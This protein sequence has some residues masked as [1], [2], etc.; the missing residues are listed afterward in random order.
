MPL[1][2]YL[3]HH[4]LL[5]ILLPI[6]REHSFATLSDALMSIST[7]DIVPRDF[8]RSTSRRKI[9]VMPYSNLFISANLRARLFSSFFEE[10]RFGIS[11]ST[12]LNTRPHLACP[13]VGV[14]G[15]NFVSM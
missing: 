4:L 1:P 6:Q 9:S 2:L 3:D 8:S 15:L 14:D 5:N 10:Y 11:P 13:M 12:K 7:S